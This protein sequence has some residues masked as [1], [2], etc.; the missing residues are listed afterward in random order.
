MTV[1][2]GRKKCKRFFKA[3][4]IAMQRRI[5][6]AANDASGPS[7]ARVPYKALNLILYSLFC[8]LFLNVASSKLQELKASYYV[9]SPVLD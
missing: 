4:N 5:Y 3:F 7:L 2:E 8:S 9:H 1:L 6:C